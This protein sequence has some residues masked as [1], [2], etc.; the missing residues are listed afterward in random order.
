MTFTFTYKAVLLADAR[1]VPALTKTQCISNG[2]PTK[3][4]ISQQSDLQ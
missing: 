1:T 3:G 4:Q 2:L